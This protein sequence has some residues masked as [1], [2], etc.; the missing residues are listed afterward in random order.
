MR[1]TRS[2]G[3]PV[4]RQEIFFHLKLLL[5]QQAMPSLV[6]FKSEDWL[7]VRTTLP[8]SLPQGLSRPHITTPRLILRPFNSSDLDALY[9]LRQQPEVMHWT[10]ASRVDADMEETATKL[11]LFL[12][13]NDTK[14]FNCAICLRETGE[15]IG[16]GGVHA[17]EQPA[18][19]AAAGPQLGWPELGYMIRK[20][21][22]GKGIATE[23]LTAFLGA[24]AGLPREG[25]PGRKVIASSAEG[26]GG[27]AT[28]MEEQ[29]VAV[30]DGTNGASQ[31]VLERCGFESFLSFRDVDMRAPDRMIDLIAYRYFPNASR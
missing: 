28:V 8:S 2:S 24:W 31:K 4:G 10:T 19:D 5:R 27:P 25:V 15:L 3:K 16:Q 13:P 30:I 22:W 29:L 17:F 11:A 14:T 21:H 12:P 9:A 23:F 7:S 6:P 26:A 20:E 18:D 1:E